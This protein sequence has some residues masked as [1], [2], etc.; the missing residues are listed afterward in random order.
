MGAAVHPAPIAVLSRLGKR[1][2]SGVTN[3]HMTATAA[4]LGRLAWAEPSANRT[5]P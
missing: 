3:V 4:Q 5:G 1:S 2:R